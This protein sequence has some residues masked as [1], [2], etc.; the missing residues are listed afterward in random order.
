M[1]EKMNCHKLF[2][3]FNSQIV[4]AKSKREKLKNSR[5]ALRS[6]IRKYFIENEWDQPKFNSQGSF[7]LQTNLNPIK[8][9]DSDGEIIEAYDLDDGVY[10]FC[11][12]KDRLTVDSY[13][14]RITKAV[15]GHAKG[16]S[17]KTTCVRV[18]YT[19]GHHIDLPIYWLEK[20]GDTPK[21]A[22]KSKGFIESDPQAFS[23]WVKEKLRFADQKQSG[24]LLRLIRYAKAWKNYREYANCSLKL[25][26]GFVLTI[27]F[28]QE[29]VPSESDDTS[30]RLTLERIYSTLKNKY[31]CKR[32]TT[33]TDEDLLEKYSKESFLPELKKFW[34]FANDADGSDCEKESSEIWRK[35]FGD[36]FPLGQV[37]GASENQTMGHQPKRHNKFQPSKPYYAKIN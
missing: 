21:L 3:K 29:Y 8:T 9:K 35:C 10:I 22:H 15:Q 4:L 1:E 20:E 2:G 14:S 11:P 30:L 13:H 6:K 12:E 18:I 5:R 28:C 17:D 26:S 33:P 16:E 32:P 24:Q 25:P 7:P 27:L 37:T 31:E 19:D 23:Y 34:D 36:R